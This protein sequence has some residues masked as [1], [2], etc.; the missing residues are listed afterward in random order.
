MPR[1]HNINGV[2]TQ[3]TSAEETARDAEEAQAVIDTATEDTR[4]AT[5][6]ALLAKIKDGSA[7]YAELLEHTQYSI[8]AK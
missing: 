6:D 7:T 4:Q 5:I 3:Y 1:F 8:G 2:R